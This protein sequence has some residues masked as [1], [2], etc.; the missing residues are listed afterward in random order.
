MKK[1]QKIQQASRQETLKLSTIF[2]AYF[3]SKLGILPNMKKNVYDSA[4]LNLLKINSIC[5]MS[6]L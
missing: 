2:H 4:K 6:I 5:D 1:K 3:P